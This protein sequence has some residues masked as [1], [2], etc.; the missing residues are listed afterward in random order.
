MVPHSSRQKPGCKDNCSAGAGQEGCTAG[1]F[2]GGSPA[3]VERQQC[4]M[5]QGFTVQ[6]P[7][8]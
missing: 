4:Q 3:R 7:T 6:D 2:P 8:L 1:I 5:K